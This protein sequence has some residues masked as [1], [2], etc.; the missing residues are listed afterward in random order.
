MKSITVVTSIPE[1]YSHQDFFETTGLF[2]QSVRRFDKTVPIVVFVPSKYVVPENDLD[3]VVV[4]RDLENIDLLM[5]NVL[6]VI[7]EYITTD[8][9]IYFTSENLLLKPINYD[10][11]MNDNIYVPITKM[12]QGNSYFEFE[13]AIHEMYYGPNTNENLILEYMICGRTD[14]T[15][16]KEF[17]ETSSDI[18]KFLKENEERVKSV[19]EP[20][21]YQYILPSA[22][23][24]ALNLLMQLNKYNFVNFP[25]A[26]IS[27]HPGLTEKYNPVT[28]ESIF[29][30]YSG[31]F[32]HNVDK[33]LDIPDT[34]T[35][36]WL[37]KQ[38]IGVQPKLALK[39]I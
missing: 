34:E 5:S 27:M 37:A 9:F 16:W 23:L 33:F 17:F 26:F 30:Q 13:K 24:V 29:Y 10:Q 31:L 6:S 4:H 7:P 21:L 12:E 32:H 28:S 11:Y 38:I 8:Y 20:Y 15:L 22:D 18:L 39:L 1:F 14:S 19:Y 25:N 3:I 2:C 35:K 36:R